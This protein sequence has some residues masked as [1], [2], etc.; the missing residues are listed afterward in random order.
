MQVSEEGLVRDV[1]AARPLNVNTSVAWQQ[2]RVGCRAR[3]NTLHRKRRRRE[4]T[5]DVSSRSTRY[6]PTDP[7]PTRT[8]HRRAHAIWQ[9]SASDCSRSLAT[10]LGQRMRPCVDSVSGKGN[11]LRPA[12]IVIPTCHVIPTLTYPRVSLRPLPSASSAKSPVDPIR[13]RGT[14]PCKPPLE[15]SRTGATSCSTHCRRRSLNVLRII[16]PPRLGTTSRFW[17]DWS[18]GCTPISWSYKTSCP[19]SFRQTTTLSS[20][21]QRQ[22]IETWIRR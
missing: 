11:A 17:M 9:S 21:G 3:A 20:F 7:Q 15:S 8:S 16:V 13:P 1:D 2:Q 10:E 22:C 18:V 19:S 4:T 6:M 14:G 12:V 5:R